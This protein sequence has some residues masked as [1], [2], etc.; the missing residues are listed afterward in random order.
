M[1]FRIALAGAVVAISTSSASAQ[2][3]AAQKVVISQAAIKKMGATKAKTKTPFTAK[4]RIVRRSAIA[5]ASSGKLGP[6]SVRES[7]KKK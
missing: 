2:A 3:P 1:N 6:T 4:V 5:A 7:P